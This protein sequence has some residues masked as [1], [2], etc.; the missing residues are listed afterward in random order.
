MH[1]APWAEQPPAS[2]GP[3]DLVCGEG[4]GEEEEQGLCTL[5]LAPAFCKDHQVQPRFPCMVRAGLYPLAYLIHRLALRPPL[6]VQLSPE[7]Y[8]GLCQVSSL[9]I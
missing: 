7:T 6:A 2:T 8:G 9:S 1:S 5:T 4:R 3:K